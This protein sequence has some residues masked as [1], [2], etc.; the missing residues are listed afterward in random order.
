MYLTKTLAVL[1]Y[2]EARRATMAEQLAE[3][4][5]RASRRAIRKAFR[6]DVERFTN[7]VLGR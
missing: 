1:G 5:D 4:A 2:I 6:E 7:R 3:H